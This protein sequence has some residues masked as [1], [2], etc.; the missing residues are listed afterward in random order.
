MALAGVAAADTLTISNANNAATTTGDW[1]TNLT[2][3]AVI[4]SGSANYTATNYTNSFYSVATNVGNGGTY[5]Y[6]L[7]FSLSQDITLNSL[8]FDVFFHNAGG[9]TQGYNR[10]A[11]CAITLSPV[12]DSTTSLFSTS[13]A[14]TSNQPENYNGNAT[15]SGAA[16]DTNG[17]LIVNTT[18]AVQ[19]DGSRV[20]TPLVTMS[21]EITLT[22]GT[23]YELK[24]SVA[25][26][27]TRGGMFVGIGNITM[28]G[29]V[30]PEPATATLSLLALAGLAV[31]RRRK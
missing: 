28:D 10:T 1:F 18:T 24:I 29:Q 27:D 13:V 26:G 14:A 7:T 21:D 17:N 15:Y 11:N 30:I 25:N 16:Y 22:T 3:N 8:A 4:T 5:D 9:K 2:A 12:A 20:A 19:A 31:R 23:S 6:V